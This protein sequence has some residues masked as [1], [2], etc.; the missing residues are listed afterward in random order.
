M[1]V[2]DRPD[3]ELLLPS[4]PVDA[5]EIARLRK[6]I[7]ERREADKPA[8]LNREQEECQWEMTPKDVA[9]FNARWDAETRRIL[10]G[11]TPQQPTM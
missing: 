9:D 1:R 8:A 6:W 10:E 2:K 7:T 5:K 3:L 11:E 4:S